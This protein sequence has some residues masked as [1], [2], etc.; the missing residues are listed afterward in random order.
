MNLTKELEKDLDDIADYLNQY[1]FGGT[2]IFVTGATGLIGSLIVR[3][4]V[5]YNQKYTQKIQVY[6]LVRNAE[7]AKE[8][9]DSQ[10]E[11][12]E[13]IF[14]DVCDEFPKDIQS[15][16]LIHTA[17]PTTSQFL[18]ENPVEAIESICIGTMNV[19]RYAR[20][21]QVK[22]M[23]NLS[24]ME[25]FGQTRVDEHCLS[26]SELGYIDLMNVRNC[27]PESKR[28]CECLCKSYAR[29]YG[30]N[31]KTARLAQ[32]FGAGVL[33]TENRV[34]AQFARSAVR[35]E[36]IVLHTT[37][38][39]MGNYCYTVD[40]IKAI[41]LLLR[42]G[43][44]GETYTVVNESSTMTIRHMAQMVADKFS[45][46]KSQV[47]LDIPE[48]NQYGYAPIT[49]MRLSS[50]RLRKLGWQPEVSLVETYRR[51]IPSLIGEEK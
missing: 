28:L 7:K 49:K 41:L 38:E 1:A 25:A 48:D 23:V 33:P 2:S 16:Y 37:G 9:Y 36:N 12:I 15:D 44:S 43:E 6:A 17:S 3:A 46:G 40:A 22:G 42:E 39:S 18:L 30:L 35:G 11:C 24:S 5:R 50:E 26:E 20:N 4:I 29:E 19:L 31:V 51:M 47:V 8:I 14:Q 27:Y 10:V 32:V 21:V 45:D 34:F 13:Y